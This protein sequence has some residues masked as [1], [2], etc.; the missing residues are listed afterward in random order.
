M[1]EKSE[2]RAEILVERQAARSISAVSTRWRPCRSSHA[3]IRSTAMRFGK[4]EKGAVWLDLEQQVLRREAE[5]VACPLV[6]SPLSSVSLVVPRT[7]APS[8]PRRY[9]R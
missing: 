4:T 8:S 3:R 6:R 5:V 7:A 2:H 9:R 1:T